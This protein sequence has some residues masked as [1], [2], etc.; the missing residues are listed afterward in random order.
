MLRFIKFMTCIIFTPIYIF[1]LFI[2][3]KILNWTYNTNRGDSL[4][5]DNLRIIEEIMKDAFN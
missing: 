2:Y 5:V 3:G 1:N 4:I